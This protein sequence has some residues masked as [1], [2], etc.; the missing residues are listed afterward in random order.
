MESFVFCPEDTPV[1]NVKEIAFQGA[2]VWKVSGLINDC[3]KLVA[4]GKSVMSWFD[5]STL[6]E[7]YR[8][9]GKRRWDWNWLN[10]WVGNCLMSLCIQPV[11]AQG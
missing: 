6:K 1:V 7:R 3:G 11:V 8:I 5:V 10:K 4:E 9:E 2:H